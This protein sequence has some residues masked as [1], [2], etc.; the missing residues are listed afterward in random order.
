MPMAEVPAVMSQMRGL[1]VG[2]K[3]G[4]GGEGKVEGFWEDRGEGLEGVGG[5]GLCL[6]FLGVGWGGEHFCCS[7]EERR[8]HRW[9]GK[10]GVD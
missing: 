5:G 10:G 2:G 3:W 1:G 8:G 6:I 9:G 4:E 7:T